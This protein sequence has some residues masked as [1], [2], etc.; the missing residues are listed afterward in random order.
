MKNISRIADELVS[1]KAVKNLYA[2]M[3]EIE[4]ATRR[5]DVYEA[6]NILCVETLQDNELAQCFTYLE[7]VHD[8][9][10]HLI[11][12]VEEARKELQE[13]AT[14]KAIKLLGPKKWEEV[15]KLF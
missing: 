6:W 1:K 4:D 11:R 2:V 9:H 7:L 8:Y 14:K 15:R 5:N 13:I 10:K 12:G 3:K